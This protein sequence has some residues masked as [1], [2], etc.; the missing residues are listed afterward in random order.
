MDYSPAKG[1]T[2]HEVED[3]IVSLEPNNDFVMGA[4]PGAPGAIGDGLTP[5]GRN[6]DG[7]GRRRNR[8][9]SG[10]AAPGTTLRHID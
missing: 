9:V 4:S 6:L 2:S 5:R 10:V 1:S 8:T 3:G 7:I